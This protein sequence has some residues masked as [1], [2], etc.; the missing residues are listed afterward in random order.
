MNLKLDKRW[1]RLHDSNWTCPSCGSQHQ[2]IFDLSCD[3]PDFW[4]RN[5]E[6]KDNSDVLN[7]SDILTEDFC[8]IENEDFFIR[9][10]LELPII[11]SNQTFGFGV[12][13]SI[14]KDNFDLYLKTFD[15]GQQ[16]H[17]G[18]WFGWFSNQLQGFPETINL[19]CHIY[20]NDENTRPVI[21]LEPTDHPLSIAQQ[22]GI[23]FDELLE[24][25]S[26]NGHDIRKAISE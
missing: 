16:S 7:F 23:T 24:I 25:Y 26:E 21:E 20:P 13:S 2:G 22:K 14:S 1:Q 8:K 12:W 19:K 18:P 10:V 17:L 4:Q 6:I 11:E 5:E 15:E 9:C 3:K